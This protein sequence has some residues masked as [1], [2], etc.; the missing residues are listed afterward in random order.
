[1]TFFFAAIYLKRGRGWKG[2][3]ENKEKVTQVKKVC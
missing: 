2:K 3:F 1:M